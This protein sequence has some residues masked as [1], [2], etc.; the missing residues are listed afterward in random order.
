[1]VPKKENIDSKLGLFVASVSNEA[2]V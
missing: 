1:V 2:V